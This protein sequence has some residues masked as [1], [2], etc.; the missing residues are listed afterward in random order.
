M[1]PLNVPA[2]V[3]DRLYATAETL[4]RQWRN[5][6]LPDIFDGL[7]IDAVLRHL[8]RYPLRPAPSD[9][10]LCRYACQLLRKFWRQNARRDYAR[11]MQARA[12]GKSP[13]ETSL[14][15][16][17]EDTAF[18]PQTTLYSHCGRAE[19]A[20][21]IGQ[22]VV[23]Q[24]VAWGTPR[25]WAW[26]VVWRA[27]GRTL[28]EVAYLMEERFQCGPSS[29]REL[30]TWDRRAYRTALARVRETFAAD[31]GQTAFI[32]TILSSRSLR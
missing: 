19:D 23:Q 17:R 25:E 2:C 20:G 7:M 27:S 30:E 13:E 18:E 1:Y 8:Q 16:L 22:A 32:E 12:Q 3:Y 9:A 4:Q 29:M 14:E 5:A 28:D 11:L 10:Q 21:E 24:L 26:A 31:R 15:R 6:Q